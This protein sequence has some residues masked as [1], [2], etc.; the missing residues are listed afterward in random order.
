MSTIT[1]KNFAKQIN[2]DPERLVRQL[3]QAGVKGKGVDDVLN[4]DEKRQ[5]LDFLRGNA[6]STQ[7]EA[8]PTLSTSPRSK[9]TVNRKTTSEIQQTSRTGTTRTVQVEVKKKRTFVKKEVLLEQE[10]QRLQQEQIVKEQ[11]EQAVK[12]QAEQEAQ[13]LEAAKKA[14]EERLAAEAL[15]QEAKEQE[16]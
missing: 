8:K 1:I 9:I 4:D 13:A 16:Q 14:E 10:K 6:A 11:A 3:D 5:L 7:A 2:L 15:E 12:L